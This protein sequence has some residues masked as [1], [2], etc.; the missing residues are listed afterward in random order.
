MIRERI[1]RISERIEILVEVWFKLTI[2]LHESSMGRR[3][4]KYHRY[5]FSTKTLDHCTM[6]CFY[7]LELLYITRATHI[8]SSIIVSGPSER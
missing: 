1:R 6:N 7:H 4:M 2:A 8:K 3:M 5:G